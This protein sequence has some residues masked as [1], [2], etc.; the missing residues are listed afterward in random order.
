[1]DITKIAKYNYGYH[2]IFS[3]RYIFSSWMEVLMRDKTG[4][5]IVCVLAKILRERTPEIVHFDKETE[6]LEHKV[7]NIFKSH[8]IHHL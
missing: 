3:Y 4:N 7:Q 6:Y 2:Y 1:M 8:L 5:E